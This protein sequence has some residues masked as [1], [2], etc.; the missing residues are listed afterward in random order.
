M[1]DIEHIYLAHDIQVHLLSKNPIFNDASRVEIWTR[2]V[3]LSILQRLAHNHLFAAGRQSH[4]HVLQL[5][6]RTDYRL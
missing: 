4:D 6:V 3:D 1:I 2:A 5:Q